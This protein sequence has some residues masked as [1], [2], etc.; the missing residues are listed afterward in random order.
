MR[1]DVLQWSRQCTS[2]ATSKVSVHNIPPVLPIQVASSCFE[3]VHVYIVGPFAPDRG[4]K[5]LLTVI[6]RTTRWPEAVPIAD[7]AA[8]TILQ[9]FLEIWVSY[10]GIPI[11]VTSDR[12]AQFT[13]DLWRK[14]LKRLGV[15]TETTMA[16]HPQAN[17]LVERFHRTL[18]AALWCAVRSSQSWSRALPWVLLGVRNAPKADTASSTA[19]VVF[20]TPLRVPCLCF[21]AE[22]GRTSAQQLELARS[23]V[24]KFSP[25]SLDLR[26]FKVSTFIAKALR[27]AKFVSVRDDRLGKPGL[28][29]R[30]IGPYRLLRRDWDN[31]TFLLECGRKEDSVALSRL[32]EAA[33]PEEA[34]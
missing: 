7:T 26:R 6:D 18:K 24:E 20:G 25:E 34:T 32:K 23:D 16:Y 21:E 29:P 5:Y 11:T 9:A 3:H 30:Y 8:E 1:R 15:N 31:N 22:Q 19:E 13:S 33:D 14:A 2:C 12:G 28:A 10:Y 17:G 27:T 4:F